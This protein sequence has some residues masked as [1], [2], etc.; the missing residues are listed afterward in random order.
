MVVPADKP[1]QGVFIPA[2]VGVCTGIW[3]N[4][5]GRITIDVNYYWVVVRAPTSPLLPD[6]TGEGDEG[7]D[8]GDTS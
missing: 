6:N 7:D 3:P 1:C 2:G 8:S 5:S 4:H